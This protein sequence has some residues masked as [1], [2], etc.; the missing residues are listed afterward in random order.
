MI[1]NM[2]KIY[3]KEYRLMSLISFISIISL[4]NWPNN[5]KDINIY[6]INIIIGYKINITYNYI[7]LY[8]S[9]VLD[10]LI[11]ISIIYERYYINEVNKLVYIIIYYI[12][13][14]IYFSSNDLITI[15]L[16]YEFQTIP[17]LLI[18]N[19][20]FNKINIYNKKGIGISNILLIL[21]SII[22]GLLLYNSFYN[23]YLLN[24]INNINHN[25]SI[26]LYNPNHILL[27]YIILNIMISG[28]I[29]L[30]IF[31][32]H[33][34][35]GKVHVEAPTIGSILLAGISLKTGFYIHYLFLSLIYYINNNF[36]YKY[37]IDI[38]MDI[39]LI[40]LSYYLSY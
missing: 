5:I 2:L 10:I 15:S 25:V 28:S 19:N 33:I 13:N 11:W 29:K 18:I 7:G 20:N 27:S 37:F 40:A 9:L 17:L 21:Y 34:W 36:Y 38:L 1:I 32:F 14:N 12:I 3:N 26:L 39:I 31:P 8:M 23:I 6:I 16:I 4:M 22:S 30:S 35:L 24:N